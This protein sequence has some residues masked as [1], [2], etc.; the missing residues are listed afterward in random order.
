VFGWAVAFAKV[1]VSCGPWKSCCE[2]SAVGKAEHRLVRAAVSSRKLCAMG[3]IPV[4]LLKV[5]RTVYIPKYSYKP[6]IFTIS[7]VNV[8]FGK[9]NIKNFLS[10][11]PYGPHK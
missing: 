11:H 6:N 4:I 8:S 7:H 3:E 2:K 5:C 9:E 1:A 10:F